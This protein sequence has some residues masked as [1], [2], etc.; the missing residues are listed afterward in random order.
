M[1]F[2][3]RAIPDQQVMEG[4]QGSVGILPAYTPS[5]P[6]P[7]SHNCRITR[8]LH[9]LIASN[10][11]VGHPGEVTL[12]VPCDSAPKGNNSSARRF[13]AGNTQNHGRAL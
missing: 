9:V 8:H 7:T 3:R 10:P 11:G 2:R 1:T 5:S 12:P 4:R 6:R 13:N